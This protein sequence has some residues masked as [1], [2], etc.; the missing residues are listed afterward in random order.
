M[1]YL[2]KKAGRGNSRDK[3]FQLW[4]Q[5]NQPLELVSN[6]MLDST[7]NFIHN[8]P[9]KAGIVWNDYEYIYSSARDYAGSQG[10]IDIYFLD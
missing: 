4:Q 7:F 3:N 5:H 8:I 2:L 9:V 10:K 6:E 1:F